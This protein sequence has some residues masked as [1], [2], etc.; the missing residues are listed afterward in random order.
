MHQSLTQDFID[1]LYK[2]IAPEHLEDCHVVTV[3]EPEVYD[4]DQHEEHSVHGILLMGW[5]GDEPAW[6][7]QVWKML[8]PGAHLMLISPEDQPTGHTGA[9]HVED[10][11]FE[12]RDAILLAQ[13]PGMLHYVP[14]AA[15]KERN[16][17]TAHLARG[18]TGEYLWF[19]K[20]EDE[21]ELNTLQSYLPDFDLSS[22]V[23]RARI[24]DGFEDY[25]EAMECCY[26]PYPEATGFGKLEVWGKVK[27]GGDGPLKPD[28]S[29]TF[30]TPENPPP[31]TTDP[32]EKTVIW[33]WIRCDEA[34]PLEAQGEAVTLIIHIVDDFAP[35]GGS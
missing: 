22:G 10:R 2:M 19:P 17:G 15:T 18:V 28:G 8:K 14:K 30:A 26:G 23:E 33:I 20:T 35:P 31:F 3:L 11:G 25:F 9:C 1:Y 6:M 21:D 4:F 16:A 12:I 29:V 13:E 7:D 5:S 24:P 32:G 27:V 34:I